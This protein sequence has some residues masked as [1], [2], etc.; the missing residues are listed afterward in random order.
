MNSILFYS[1]ILVKEKVMNE[2]NCIL[3][4]KYSNLNV[5]KIYCTWNPVFLDIIRREP[6][7]LIMQRALP[8][9]FVV[10]LSYRY[11]ISFLEAQLQEKQ[12]HCIQD[13]NT[14]F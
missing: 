11:Y 5:F 1:R 6:T 9:A 8:P 7:S 10:H 13:T 4:L 14:H 3:Y 2:S 12:K